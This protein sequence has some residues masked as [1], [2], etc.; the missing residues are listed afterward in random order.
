MSH[1]LLSFIFIYRRDSPNFKETD[2]CIT[3]AF[4]GIRDCGFKTGYGKNIPC[5]WWKD[6]LQSSASGRR[7]SFR[8]NG[9]IQNYNIENRKSQFHCKL[10]SFTELFSKERAQAQW[11]PNTPLE[12][13]RKKTK[14]QRNKETKKQRN[15]ETKK[16][17]NKETKKQRNKKQNKTKQNYYYY[18]SEFIRYPRFLPGSSLPQ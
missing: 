10:Y 8:V 15:K 13:T 12:V 9:G 6:H 4:V 5:F 16:Q 14:K 17:R 3:H 18:C 7:D 11:P 1:S 2:D